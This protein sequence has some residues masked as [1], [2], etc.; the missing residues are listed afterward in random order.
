[1]KK[2]TL[3]IILLV[4]IMV[5]FGCEEATDYY[6]GFNQQP[7]LTEDTFE[8]GMNIFGLLRADFRADYNKSFVYIQ[9]VYRVLDNDDFEL[10]T[11]VDV[12]I[13]EIENSIVVDSFEFPLVPPDSLFNDTI[14]RSLEDFQPIPGNTYRLVCVHNRLPIAIGEAS[15]PAPP[16]VVEGTLIQ[17]GHSISFSL[18]P[19]PLIKLVDVYF[20]SPDGGGILNRYVTNDS[21]ATNVFVE[22]PAGLSEPIINIFGYD[23]NL[24]NYYAN[25]N[26]SLNFN[27]YR[28]T[29]STLESG[30]GVFGALNFTQ[31]VPEQ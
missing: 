21:A 25:S 8:E 27:K 12:K 4:L 13:Y 2:I 10:I 17:L 7:E 5:N 16:E 15:F 14:Y 11:D 6:L 26:T 3:Y 28:T 18:A 1:M 29:I 24:A 22:L 20:N 23:L 30:F 9:E 31:L 19:D